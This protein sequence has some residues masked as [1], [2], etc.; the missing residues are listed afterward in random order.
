MIW[1]RPTTIHTLSGKPE[2]PEGKVVICTEISFVS[3]ATF[4]ASTIATLSEDK[5]LINSKYRM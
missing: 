4:I 3:F 5:I 2:H 1:G